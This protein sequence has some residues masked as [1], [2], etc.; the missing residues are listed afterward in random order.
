MARTAEDWTNKTRIGGKVL[1]RAKENGPSGDVRWVVLCDCGREFE[2]SASLLRRRKTFQC[3]PCSNAAGYAKTHGGS[4]EP[5]YSV[6]DNMKRR[7]HDPRATGYHRYGGRGIFMDESWRT[8]FGI[9]RAYITSELGPKP[10][11][12]H[13]I[14]RINP[15]DGY[16]PGN[17]RWATRA[18]Q[19][20]NLSR[21]TLTV[22]SN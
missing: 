5:L 9:F 10:T 15:D 14:D 12:E 1:R 22:K 3:K 19:R 7:C 6:W 13:T 8:D 21:A 20:A 4:L 17:I 18:E 11:P 16:R 2:V